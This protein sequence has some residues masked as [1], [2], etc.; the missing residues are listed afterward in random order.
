MAATALLQRAPFDEAEPPS[1][2]IVQ[3]AGITKAYG[4][5]LAN[6]GVDLTVPKGGVV[7]LVGGNG[8]GKSTL[9]KALCGAVRPDSGTLTIDGQAL[10]LQPL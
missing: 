8:A 7:G 6:N 3:L 4:P 9:M 10:N 2:S 5:T 1:G